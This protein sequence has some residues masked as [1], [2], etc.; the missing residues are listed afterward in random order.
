MSGKLSLQQ[1]I[2]RERKRREKRG[3]P[4]P[5][6][7]EPATPAMTKRYVDNH[8]DIL[9]NIEFGFVEAYRNH[10]E[11][12]DRSINSAI[13]SF[14]LATPPPDELAAMAFVNLMQIRE[15]RNDVPQDVWIDG[16]RVILG[17]IQTHSGLRVGE[18]SYLEFVDSFTP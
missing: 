8:A 11:L 15:M 12:D 4:E 14:L 13:R 1:K 2:A 6:S 9:Q 16:L 17:S 18:T 7:L 5:V 3:R 10:P